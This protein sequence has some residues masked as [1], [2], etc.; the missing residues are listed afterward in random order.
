[1]RYNGEGTFRELVTQEA[2]VNKRSFWRY[3]GFVVLALMVLLA[4]QVSKAAVQRLLP[5]GG[6]WQPLPGWPWLRIV[7]WSNTGVAFGLFPSGGAALAALAFLVL[8]VLLWRL[9]TFLSAGWWAVASVALIVGGALG[10]LLDR[11]RLGRVVDFIAVG[12]FPVFNLADAAITLGAAL[13]FLGMWDEDQPQ[14]PA[15]DL[16]GPEI[17]APQGEER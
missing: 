5:Y 17:E 15:E 4:D 3:S 2:L 14:E 11:V 8:T 6:F 7:H 10:N 12:S 13:L 16:R 1:M 9:P